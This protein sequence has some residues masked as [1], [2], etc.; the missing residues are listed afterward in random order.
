M[1]LVGTLFLLPFTLFGVLAGSLLVCI[2][3]ECIGM[4]L[5]WPD[6]G[7]HHAEEMFEAELAQLSTDFKQGVVLSQPGQT[8]R[9]VVEE[10]GTWVFVKS[11]FTQWSAE[12]RKRADGLQRPK[13]F[14][15]YLALAHVKAQD[16]VLAAAYTVL[17][18][19]TRLAVLVLTLPLFLLAAAVGLIDGLVRRDIR[20]FT[21]AF[22]SGFVHHRA[23]ALILPLATLPWGLY[24]ALP[25]TVTPLAVLLPAAVAFGLAVDIAAA[26]FKK[27]L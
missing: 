21:S 12:A 17:V 23:R 11:G 7:W 4:A 6:E 14:R 22:E 18:F 9:G 2:T 27:Y 13:S 1:S 24:L 16:Y 20:R 19:F 8:A 15:D 26:S 3:V 5:V 10:V 25:V